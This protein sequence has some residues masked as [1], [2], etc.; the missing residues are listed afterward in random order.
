MRIEDEEKPA[1]AEEPKI[2][3]GGRD[4]DCW[5][6]WALSDLVGFVGISFIISQWL[7]RASGGLG[8][9]ICFFG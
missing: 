9:S 6:V 4:V 3:R 5:H 7:Q 8:T 2:D 1:L